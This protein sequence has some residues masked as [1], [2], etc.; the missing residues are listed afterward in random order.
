MESSAH[1]LLDSPR[2]RSEAEALPADFQCDA[3]FAA[4]NSS[5]HRSK[6]DPIRHPSTTPSLHTHRGR[7]HFRL[8]PPENARN[9]SRSVHRDKIQPTAGCAPVHRPI[10]PSPLHSLASPSQHSRPLLPSHHHSACARSRKP[11]PA[12]FDKSQSPHEDRPPLPHYPAPHASDSSESPRFPLSHPHISPVF[13]SCSA[14]TRTHRS[15]P[16]QSKLFPSRRIQTPDLRHSAR[17]KA[18]RY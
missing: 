10:L 16:H 18:A 17:S 15:K 12:L 9:P 7:S 14:S 3:S 1:S 5:A 11:C 4:A 2:N 13:H 6:S 8:F